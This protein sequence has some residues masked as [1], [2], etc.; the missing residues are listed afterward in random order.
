MERKTGDFLTFQGNRETRTCKSGSSSLC[1]VV[2]SCNYRIDSENKIAYLH[3]DGTLTKH[4]EV[5]VLKDL[6]SDPKWQKNFNIL[7]NFAQ[8]DD[9]NL[10]YDDIVEIVDE[11]SN[12]MENGLYNSKLALVATADYLYGTGRIWQQL[13]ETRRI[14]IGIFRNIDEATNWLMG[15]ATMNL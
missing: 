8:V 13:G 9:V 11:Q 10:S 2:M 14:V 6:V 15:Q 1:G 5:Q 7:Q 3:P 12:L 4:M